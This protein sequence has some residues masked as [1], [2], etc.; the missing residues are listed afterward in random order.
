M[1]LISAHHARLWNRMLGVRPLMPRKPRYRFITLPSSGTQ[2]V[3][4]TL[5][6]VKYWLD[7]IEPQNRFAQELDGLLTKYPKVNVNAMGFPVGWEQETFW[8]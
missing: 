1:S 3:Y 8:Q 7:I 2:H 4:F 5:A 6:I